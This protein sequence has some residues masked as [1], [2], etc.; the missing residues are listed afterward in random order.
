M[1]SIT[2][3]ISR[4]HKEHQ[5]W[6][7]K[8]AKKAAKEETLNQKRIDDLTAQLEYDVYNKLREEVHASCGITG[9]IKLFAGRRSLNL[10]SRP[11]RRLIVE[12]F[13]RQTGMDLEVD[14]KV[15]SDY[16]YVK[17]SDKLKVCTV[18]AGGKV[19]T[20]DY[21]QLNTENEARRAIWA[22][23][24]PEFARAMINDCRKCLETMP[25][26]YLGIPEKMLVLRYNDSSLLGRN[27]ITLFAGEFSTGSLTAR[28]DK[29]SETQVKE[30]ADKMNTMISHG[31]VE[32]DEPKDAMWVRILRRPEKVLD[33][34]YFDYED[35]YK[36]YDEVTP[37]LR[38]VLNL[39]VCDVA[40]PVMKEQ[41]LSLSLQRKLVY[42][43]SKNRELDFKLL[44]ERLSTLVHKQ[45][46]I[47]AVNGHVRGVK[48]TD[49]QFLNREE[50]WGSPRGCAHGT[51]SLDERIEFTVELDETT[52]S[53]AEVA[54][55]LQ[56]ENVIW[57]IKHCRVQYFANV[58]VEAVLD[59][60]YAYGRTRELFAENG[61]Y[62]QTMCDAE[63]L[64]VTLNGR[65][66][67]L[68]RA[69]FD[70][71]PEELKVDL[72]EV[73][74]EAFINRVAAAVQRRTDGMMS[75]GLDA[76][77]GLSYKLVF[78]SNS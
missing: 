54:K 21:F 52:T 48:V 60:I 10:V 74:D 51:M 28:Y 16:V 9:T 39:I 19:I 3:R 49:A 46:L 13:R 47:D 4:L 30:L 5:E 7:K 38:H 62:W 11:E 1:S 17:L 58:L 53:S 68:L 35:F 31:E 22:Q 32:I 71:E 12:E 55:Q 41:L 50:S 33:Q 37:E 34:P 65:E 67:R 70:C 73:K 45:H 29:L 26:K 15:G 25:N 18:M 61:K 2:Y 27:G 42:W 43:F 36:K 66:T 78:G 20:L 59:D 63:R 77:H 8:Q 64:I 56:L 57:R 75:I 40:F 69:A 24:L 14:E 44:R 76:T 6:E 23:F 72:R